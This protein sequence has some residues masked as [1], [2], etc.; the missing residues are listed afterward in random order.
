MDDPPTTL[1][2]TSVTPGQRDALYLAL[3]ESRGLLRMSRELEARRDPRG[4]HEEALRH[5]LRV[6]KG[7]QKG[8]RRI[9]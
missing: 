3:S 1:S 2:N 6:R 4:R 5:F 8:P 9:R 7:E